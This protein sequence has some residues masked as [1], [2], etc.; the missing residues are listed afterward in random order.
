MKLQDRKNVCKQNSY[1]MAY[2]KIAR[3]IGH[4]IKINEEQKYV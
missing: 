3:H 2:K 4:L 1:Y